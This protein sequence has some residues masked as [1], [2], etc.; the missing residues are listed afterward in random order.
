MQGIRAGK[1]QWK[2]IMCFCVLAITIIA[3]PGRALQASQDKDQKPA[4]LKQQT[5]FG[6]TADARSRLSDVEHQ[7]KPAQPVGSESWTQGVL[8][9]KATHPAMLDGKG[10]KRQIS[11]HKDGDRMGKGKVQLPWSTQHRLHGH[12][13]LVPTSVEQPTKPCLLLSVIM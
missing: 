4:T 12:V 3:A 9:A 1:K 6:I 13:G 10:G 7:D 5:P 8:T 2:H 11:E